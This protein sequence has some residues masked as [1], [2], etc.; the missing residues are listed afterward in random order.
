MSNTF[1]A[2]IHKED[3]LFVAQCPE[4][5]T[6]SQGETFQ[7]ALNNIKEAS[8]IYIQETHS[9]PFDHPVITTFELA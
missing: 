3:D 6:V 8:E 5:G 1:I 7:E 4:L 9:S 2:V